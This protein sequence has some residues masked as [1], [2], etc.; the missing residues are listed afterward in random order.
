MADRQD[1][2]NAPEVVDVALPQSALCF[3]L[4]FASKN[5]DDLV[6]GLLVRMRP[7]AIFSL[8]AFA[9]A[10]ATKA[11][12][13]SR[14]L[15]AVQNPRTLIEMIPNLPP[16]LKRLYG[17][18]PV[19]FERTRGA[20]AVEFF[21]ASTT[22]NGPPNRPSGYATRP[23]FFRVRADFTDPDLWQRVYEAFMESFLA[24]AY[25]G[26]ITDGILRELRP[27]LIAYGAAK[28]GARR[29]PVD[30]LAE[31]WWKLRLVGEKR[32]EVPHNGDWV[33][34]ATWLRGY[35]GISPYGFGHSLISL[36]RIGG[37][38]NEDIVLSPGPEA[39]KDK[40]AT[41]FELLIGSR[42]VPMRGEVWNMWDWAEAQVERRRLYVDYRVLPLGPDGLE[43]YR[44]IIEEYQGGEWGPYSAIAN[45]CAH[46]VLDLLNAV[47]PLDQELSITKLAPIV[48]P[49]EVI[50]EAS[51]AFPEW[52]RFQMGEP[53]RSGVKTPPLIPPTYR[54]RRGESPLYREYLIKE[55]N[56]LRDLKAQR[57]A[58][59]VR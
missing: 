4:S 17:D 33:L 10:C 9:G 24:E 49:G 40:P 54:G 2:F 5:T 25:P 27:R 6:M 41:A 58:V 30:R 11:P 51:A 29:P 38:P 20:V 42:R 45:S 13:A 22:L 12:D 50:N 32:P 23:A 47:L 53:D 52:G 39:P 48:V 26:S 14:D 44:R 35:N 59:D 57:N 3:V 19:R 1:S 7:L 21:R 43:L 28:L 37:D 55:A 46:G 56:L 8:L 15:A 34:L 16:V 36:R 31:L 18:T